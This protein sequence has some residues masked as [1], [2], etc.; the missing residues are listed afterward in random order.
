[1][2]SPFT[3]VGERAQSTRVFKDLLCLESPNPVFF[4]LQ[5]VPFPVNVPY[6]LLDCA[7]D[8]IFPTYG[9]TFYPVSVCAANFI[10]SPIVFS[11]VQ[12]R[13]SVIAYGSYELEYSARFSCN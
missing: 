13:R 5:G 6:H 7:T 8:N 11:A 10:G 4:L 3:K 1:V 9:R 2:P 12:S